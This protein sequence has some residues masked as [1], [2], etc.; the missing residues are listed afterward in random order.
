MVKLSGL[1]AATVMTTV[2][3]AGG[4]GLLGSPVL[5]AERILIPV[6]PLTVNLPV[7]DIESYVRTGQSTGDFAQMISSLPP[8]RGRQLKMVMGTRIPFGEKNLRRVLRGPMGNTLLGQLSDVM[9]PTSNNS[10]APNA[11]WET[12]LLRAAKSDGGFTLIDVI[13]EYPASEVVFDIDAAQAKMESFQALRGR[14]GGILPGGNND[15]VPNVTPNGTPNPT[16]GNG[17]VPVIP[18]LPRD[19]NTNNNGGDGIGSG[20]AGLG[21]LSSLFSIAS[22]MQ[23]LLQVFRP[24]NGLGSL[25]NVIPG[26]MMNN[27]PDM[28]QILDSLMNLR[29][30]I[31][32]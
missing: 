6:G 20:L 27:R 13:R 3:T 16:P 10:I 11:A 5:A 17:P 28:M 32:R 19:N 21:N 1:V 2:V 9:K 25:S 29:Q 22:G 31:G 23:G 14:L 12:A 18:N 8:E 24:S 7:S 15:T 26:S 30:V 4:V